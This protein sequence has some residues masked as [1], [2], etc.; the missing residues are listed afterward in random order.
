[1][2]KQKD[3]IKY[4]SDKELKY[5]LIISQG[6][7][8]IVSVILSFFLFD[9]VL[10]WFYYIEFQPKEIIY[11][12]GSTGIVIVLFDL[13]IMYLFPVKW[14]DDGG[15]NKRIFKNRKIGDIFLIVGIVSISEELLF[16]GVLQTTFGYVIASSLFA[17]VHIRYLTKPL[18]LI[19]VLITSFYIG[20]VFEL[21]HNLLVT[22]AAHFVVDFLLAV[23][24]RYQK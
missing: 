15:I 21:T 7:I 23:I 16:R 10:D 22:I 24:I 13:L 12:G 18:L 9:S 8:F 2:R 6:I 5:Q 3:V 11:F 20:W 4:L 19:S 1:M 17:L 14:Y